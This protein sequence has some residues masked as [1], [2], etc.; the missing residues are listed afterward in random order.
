MPIRPCCS[1]TTGVTERPVYLQLRDRIAAGILDG[2]HREGE[3]L[4]SVRGFAAEV[5][6]NPLT[7]ARAYSWF[8]DRDLVEVRRGVGL[9]VAE[10]ARERLRAIEREAFLSEEWPELRARLRRL[11]VDVGE[12]LE[13]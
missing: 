5:G 1:T 12:L 11:R 2:D 6:A 9:F 10:G 13:E 7:V 8:Q 3:P 4:P